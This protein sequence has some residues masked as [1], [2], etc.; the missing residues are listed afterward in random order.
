MMRNGLQNWL[1]NWSEW[2]Q[3]TLEMGAKENLAEW[4][5][6]IDEIVEPGKL[7]R[8]KYQATLWLARSH[9]LGNFRPGEW[10]KVVDRKGLVLFIEPLNGCN[11]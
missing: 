1:S 5:G 2:L 4:E 7:W 8:V 10:V 6:T 3:P 11:H 9:Q